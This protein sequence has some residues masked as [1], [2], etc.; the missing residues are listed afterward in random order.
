MYQGNAK[1]LFTA[2]TVNTAVRKIYAAAP[3]RLLLQTITPPSNRLDFGDRPKHAPL[4]TL[5]RQTDKKSGNGRKSK[6]VI[7]SFH[8]VA[9]I[10][11]WHDRNARYPAS[12]SSGEH[13]KAFEPL[14]FL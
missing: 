6:S 13:H 7:R 8:A 4:Q 1:R 10:Q 5:C 14:R 11:D 9:P 2:A 3:F 12:F